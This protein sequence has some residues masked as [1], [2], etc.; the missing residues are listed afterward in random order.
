[1]GELASK[2]RAKYPGS[3]DSL[4]DADLESRIIAKYPGVYDHLAGPQRTVTGN[5]NASPAEIERGRRQFV[6]DQGTVGTR[7]V[8][9]ANQAFNPNAKIPA[10][11]G[12]GDFFGRVLPQSLTQLG[13][14]MAQG[15]YEGV[16]GQTDPLVKS[17]S[18]LQPTDLPGPQMERNAGRTLNSL[19]EAMAAPTGLMGADRAKEAWLTDPAGSALAVAPTLKLAGMGAKSLPRPKGATLAT[20]IDKGIDKGIRPGVEGNRT[21][22]QSSQYHQRAQQAVKTIIDNHSQGALKLTDE[23]GEATPT[24]PKNLRQFSQAIDQSKR[25]I[26]DQYNHMAVASGEAGA[27]VDL[28]PIPAELMN[29]AN[30]RALQKSAPGVADYARTRAKAFSGDSTKT[31]GVTSQRA[32]TFT[33][34]E[35]QQ[36]IAIYNQSLEAFNKNPSYDTASRAYIDSLIVNH[37]RKGLD[38]SIEKATGP[39]YQSLKNE[40]GALKTIEKDVSRRAIVDARKN[41]KGL[42]DFSDV[43]SGGQVVH[44]LMSMN[45]A[46]VGTGIASKIIANIYKLKNDPNRIVSTMFDKAGKMYTPKQRLDIQ[47][48]GVP[49]APIVQ[50]SD[51]AVNTGNIVQ[52][53]PVINRMGPVN[54]GNIVQPGPVINRMGPINTG[55]IVQPGPLVNKMAPVNTGGLTQPGPVI[56]VMAGVNTG[57]IVQPTPKPNPSARVNSSGLDAPANSQLS[58]NLLRSTPVKLSDLGAKPATPMTWRQFLSAKMGPAMKSEGSHAAAIRKLAEEWKTYKKQ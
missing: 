38:A 3:Y 18:T 16:K 1:M 39:G 13:P 6:A 11:D 51:M 42:L 20:V 12:V 45:P 54:T 23:F 26:Y 48:Q 43:F 44:G 22:A 46:T 28:S 31:D 40:Y 4:P 32:N 37:L 50:R 5:L 57:G 36:A 41:P 33:A 34:E 52:P 25:N 27:I 17:L 2:I 56:N 7:A 10:A 21:F 53:G 8:D 35:A 47:A 14:K 19:A 24:L 15:I 58:P 9:M 29:V 49:P 55:D 30:N